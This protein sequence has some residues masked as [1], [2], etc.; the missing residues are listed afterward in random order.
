MIDEFSD[1]AEETAAREAAEIALG[2]D[3]SWDNEAM[4]RLADFLIGFGTRLQ[5][6]LNAGDAGFLAE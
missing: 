5:A 2:S 3:A 1:Q 4:K 6:K